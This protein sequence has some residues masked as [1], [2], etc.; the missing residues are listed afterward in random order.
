MLYHLGTENKKVLLFIDII[1]FGNLVR[2]NDG[3]N[4]NDGKP[5]DIALMFPNFYNKLMSLRY[6][7]EC[8]ESR[9][10]KFLWASDTIVISTDVEN[11]NELIEDLIFLQNQLYSGEMAFRGCVC[12]GNLYHEDN[13]W[14]EPLV[15]AADIEKKKVRYPRIIIANEELGQLPL[16]SE[17]LKYF[18]QDE[19]NVEYAS[20]MPFL[21]NIDR[22]LL[23]KG[24]VVHSTI[25]VYTKMVVQN[26]NDAPEKVKYKWQWMAKDLIETLKKRKITI[27][28]RLEVEEQRGCV[29]C[30]LDTLL[31]ELSG[32]L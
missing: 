31:L 18:E 30:N 12:I 23:N 9:N 11:A 6:S 29:D 20:F 8:Q 24:A 1:G 27:R 21:P 3:F 19:L 26:Y 4:A 25:N 22:I 17:H 32:I 13:V 10:I 2:Q 16:S 7:K 28:E 5:H 14:G 15:R